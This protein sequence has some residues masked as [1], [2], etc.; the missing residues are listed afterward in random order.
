VTYSITQR[1]VSAAVLQ[2]RENLQDAGRELKNT[3][4]GREY[5]ESTDRAQMQCAPTGQAKISGPGGRGQASGWH[6][7]LGFHDQMK[8]WRVR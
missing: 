2:L 3:G 8:G 6:S 7:P 4:M 1:K 5:D